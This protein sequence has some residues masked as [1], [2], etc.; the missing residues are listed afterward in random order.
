MLFIGVYSF[1]FSYLNGRNNNNCNVLFRAPMELSVFLKPSCDFGELPQPYVAFLPFL[2][3][4]AVFFCFGCFILALLRNFL[5]YLLNKPI[6]A[7][8][9]FFLTPEF[10]HHLL[11]FHSNN[12]GSTFVR[13]LLGVSATTVAKSYHRSHTLLL[14]KN[15]R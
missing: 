13:V 1:T 10:F 3:L 15:F 11:W 12:R 9:C 2:C 14:H 7:F 5:A 6:L 4:I 8:A